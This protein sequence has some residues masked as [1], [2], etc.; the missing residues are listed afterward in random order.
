[1]NGA[2]V[3]RGLAAAAQ[4]AGDAAVLRAGETIA[5]RAQGVS[6]VMAVAEAG[7]VRV[8]GRGL[9]ARVF[10][11]R[12]RAADGRLRALVTGDER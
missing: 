7:A 5:E 9:L 10:G 12:R 4:Q 3:M 11:S 6:G 1:M 8:R 2:A